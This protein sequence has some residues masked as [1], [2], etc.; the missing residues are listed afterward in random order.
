MTLRAHSPI[1]AFP[2]QMTNAV[3]RTSEN[4]DE[5]RVTV[6]AM[7]ELPFDAVSE[8]NRL[9]D[10]DVRF[11]NPFF[12]IE[13]H[14]M[15]ADLREN[16]FVANLESPTGE[17]LGVFPFERLRA[18]RG[19]PVGD[20]FSDYHG[21]ISRQDFSAAQLN[22]IIAACDLQSFRFHHTP[23]FQTGFRENACYSE[24]SPRI[25]V[26]RGFD[27]YCEDL[28]S[29]Q[30]KFIKRMR[31]RTRKLQRDH[32]LVKLKFSSSEDVHKKMREW[33]AYACKT[34]LRQ[35][36]Y[37][38]KWAVEMFQRLLECNDDRLSGEISILQ[39]GGTPVAMTYLL[40]SFN[41]MHVWKIA[42]NPDFKNY[43]PGLLVLYHLIESA[44]NSGVHRIDLA[45]GDERFKMTMQNSSI[46]VSEGWI[47]GS[48]F[49]KRGRAAWL[50]GKKRLRDS[51][52]E[53]PA[54]TCVRWF[55]NLGSKILP[56]T[57]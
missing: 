44:A 45:R 12:R 22:S 13:M 52:W 49:V 9:C 6:H 4:C 32:G 41:D 19:Q 20:M 43:S 26:S 31:Q 25:D 1:R 36:V 48:T 7:S 35:N 2:E 8:W 30:S 34:Q 42:T 33:K 21:V 28:R 23:D 29:R 27:S 55:R 17:W 54:K 18:Q 57:H 24:A 39:A 46:M 15:F 16:A 37:A 10:E 38:E 50:S 14:Q 51:R 47:G 56:Q 53:T 5:L 40:R 11:A 3:L